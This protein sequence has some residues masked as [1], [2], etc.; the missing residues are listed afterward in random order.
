MG[1]KMTRNREQ[2]A[3]FLYEEGAKAVR[4][5]GHELNMLAG[6][7]IHM[8]KGTVDFQGPLWP[9]RILHDGREI[10][11]NRFIDY[12]LRPAREGLGL[13]S[14]YFLQQVLKASLHNGQEALDLVRTE[15]AK[16]YVNFD[17]IAN[18]E[19]S[20]A[21]LERQPGLTGLHNKGTKLVPFTKGGTDRQA[22]QLAQ[23][24]PDLADKVRAGTMK[25]SEALLEAG[26]RKKVA[27]FEQIRKLLPKLTKAECKELQKLL[28]D[29]LFQG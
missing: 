15:L 22:A 20:T 27:P 16:E 23:R 24:R 2:E 29:L 14:L 4:A 28:D 21:L 11:L 7:L 26:I 1:R 17:N 9:L 5:G 10:R 18:R 6:H 13:S 19:H 12:L 25:L 3:G 8:I